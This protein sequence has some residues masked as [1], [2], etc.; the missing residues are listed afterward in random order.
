MFGLLT[1]LFTDLCCIKITIV[2]FTA[3]CKFLVD[4]IDSWWIWKKNEWMPSIMIGFDGNRF[5]KMDFL[6]NMMESVVG[7]RWSSSVQSLINRNLFLWI[8]RPLLKGL[9]ARRQTKMKKRDK[10]WK[11]NVD[12]LAPGVSRDLAK[13][14]FFSKSNVGIFFCCLGK[15]ELQTRR[16]CSWNG[17]CD[18]VGKTERPRQ[19][20]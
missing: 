6:D 7:F 8:S 12:W 16:L 14:F 9:T 19:K 15:L 17:C 5:W 20:K 10:N 4:W 13:Y 3:H 2:F 11:K 18:L 1:L